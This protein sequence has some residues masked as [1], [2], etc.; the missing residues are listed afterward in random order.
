PMLPNDAYALAAFG[1]AAVA[2]LARAARREAA[3][4]SRFASLIG[5]PPASTVELVQRARWHRLRHGIVEGALSPRAL[6]DAFDAIR[7]AFDPQAVSK[8]HSLA[9]RLRAFKAIASDETHLPVIGL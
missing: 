1:I 3:F 7:E 9:T 5:T 4:R 2:L 6:E 8:L